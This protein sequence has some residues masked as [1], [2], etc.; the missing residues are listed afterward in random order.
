MNRLAVKQALL[1]TQHNQ[2]KNRKVRRNLKTRLSRVPESKCYCTLSQ[3]F[4]LRGKHNVAG[5]LTGCCSQLLILT[6]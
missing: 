1:F 2:L 4:H 5:G 6:F 3:E